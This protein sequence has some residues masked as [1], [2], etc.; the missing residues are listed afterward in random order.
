MPPLDGFLH[1]GSKRCPPVARVEHR[2]RRELHEVPWPAVGLQ[3]VEIAGRDRHT[4]DRV[5]KADVEARVIVLGRVL[6]I[7]Q[8]AGPLLFRDV[9]PPAAVEASVML[10]VVRE[11]AVQGR[12]CGA[13][14]C[15]TKADRVSRA[16]DADVRVRDRDREQALVDRLEPP[17]HRAGLV[18]VA[19]V[20]PV[21]GAV[22]Q[23]DW[24]R[25]LVDDGGRGR[26][27]E[28]RDHFG[29]RPDLRLPAEATGVSAVVLDHIVPV[30]EIDAPDD[31][32]V[33]VAR[34]R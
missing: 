23:D 1:D 5:G 22:A 28:A 25:A 34:H 18:I 20:E 11:N 7:D 19:V 21:L 32:P 30:R 12:A 17:A 26:C 33:A 31:G 29:R 9:L 16:D 8:Q 24:L 27:I 2:V 10:P 6:A 14:V 3:F 4:R 13:A 15:V